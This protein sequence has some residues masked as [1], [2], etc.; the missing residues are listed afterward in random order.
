ML[1]LLMS[2]T[3]S[4]QMRYIGFELE[5]GKKHIVLCSLNFKRSVSIVDRQSAAEA[6]MFTNLESLN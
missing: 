4:E 2:A 6:I 1:P 5:A 3:D